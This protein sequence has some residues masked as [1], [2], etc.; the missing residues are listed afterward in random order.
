MLFDIIRGDIRFSEIIIGFISALIVIFITMPIHECAH[1]FVAYKLGDP[2]AKSMG[3]LTL[4]PL[5]HI[6]WLG[7]AAIFLIGIG[8]AEPVPV[9]MYYF[10]RPKRDMALSALAGPVSNLLLAFVA[11]LFYNL[12]FT[13]SEIS[14]S[15]ALVFIGL[16]F[17]YVAIINIS[18]AV[19][20]LIPIAP[21]D[22]SKILAAILPDRAYAKFMQLE[23]YSYIILLVVMVSGVLDGPLSFLVN[24]VA[25]G[26]NFVASLP[27]NLIF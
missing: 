22:G 2:T 20:N 16:V 17:F 8:W 3:R 23:K 7:A 27:F 25:Y 14:I 10:K 5:A 21:L 15:R 6:N 19:F 12:F 24:N 9:N 4:N 1:A 18:L 11:L 13:L 26:L